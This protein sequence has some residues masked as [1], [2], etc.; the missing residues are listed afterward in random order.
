MEYCP[1]CCDLQGLLVIEKLG[2]DGVGVLVVED[3][4]ALVPTLREDW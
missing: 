4:D 1:D 3:K 2:V